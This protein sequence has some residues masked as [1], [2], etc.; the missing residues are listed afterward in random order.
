MKIFFFNDFISCHTILHFC[1]ESD[2]FMITSPLI[3]K[4]TACLML[5]LVVSGECEVPLCKLR[6]EKKWQNIYNIGSSN[7]CGNHY[8]NISLFLP[9][10]LD[11]YM[12]CDILPH[13]G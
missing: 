11:C 12:E 8:Y 13:A 5:I 10:P 4:H 1:Q 3:K 2:K 7:W 6:Y 9:L